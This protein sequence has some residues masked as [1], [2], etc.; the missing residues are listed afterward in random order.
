M[1]TIHTN[2]GIGAA[3]TQS[4]PPPPPPHTPTSSSPV[5]NGCKQENTCECLATWNESMKNLTF[6]VS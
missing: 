5:I 1:H 6:A 4:L 2:M 3:A